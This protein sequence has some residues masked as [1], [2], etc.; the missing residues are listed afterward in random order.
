MD[1]NEKP[2]PSKLIPSSNNSAESSR[3]S[4][5]IDASADP[6]RPRS[7]L[8]KTRNLSDCEA[9]GENSPEFNG[10]T[11]GNRETIITFIEPID[12]HDDGID[13]V[14]KQ[15]RRE[16]LKA[17]IREHY[18][19]TSPWDKPGLGAADE[20]FDEDSDAGRETPKLEDKK[21]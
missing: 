21:E 2:D 19:N 1:K 17:K 8:C 11:A 18:R 16:K 9:D 15:E 13:E 4:A 6:P 7:I 5:V 3:I 10:V 20:R 12:V 14:T